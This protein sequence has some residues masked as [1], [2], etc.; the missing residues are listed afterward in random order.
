MIYSSGTGA[1]FISNEQTCA[2]L[3]F[4]S[5]CATAK[6]YITVQDF[7]FAKTYIK[8]LRLAVTNFNWKWKEAK[9]GGMNHFYSILLNQ[10][11]ARHVNIHSR[12][13]KLSRRL[14]RRINWFIEALIESNAIAPKEGTWMGLS[15]LS[16]SMCK[17]LFVIR[18]KVSLELPGSSR[19]MRNS[20]PPTKAECAMNKKRG[21]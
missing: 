14:I 18:R 10:D 7:A 6:L 12:W 11:Y 21:N 9:N 13:K 15:R 16:S 5:Y 17:G 2:K 4:D 19:L 8:M 1:V 20:A 3:T